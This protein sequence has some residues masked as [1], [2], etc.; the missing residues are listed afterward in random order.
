MFRFRH[1]VLL[2]MTI[3]LA[4]CGLFGASEPVMPP[5]AAPTRVALTIE[6]APDIN[7]D[8]EGRGAP[9]QLRIYEL[10]GSAAFESSDF[11][12]I[13]DKDQATLGAD[14]ASRKDLLLRPGD[15]KILMLEPGAGSQFVGIFAAYRQLE[16]AR[17]RVSTPIIPARTKLVEVRIRGTQLS[18][19]TPAAAPLGSGGR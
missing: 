16:N 10:R 6:A 2:A 17:W 9:V 5:V 12:A 19:E 8:N 4:A 7:P 1:V 13:Y 14:L 11:F 15:R 3:P 18:L